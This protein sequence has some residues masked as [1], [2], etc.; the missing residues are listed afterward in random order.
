MTGSVHILR[1]GVALI[2]DAPASDAD[3]ATVVPIGRA[4]AAGSRHRHPAGGARGRVTVDDGS[5]EPWPTAPDDLEDGLPS[6]RSIAH[7]LVESRRWALAAAF[8]R[9]ADLVHGVAR[10]LVGHDHADDVTQQVFVE[11]W[12]SRRSFD[13]S[14]GEVPGWLVGIARNVARSYMRD[15]GPAT[16]DVDEQRDADGAAPGADA[17]VDHLVVASAFRDLPAT[18]R[19]VLELTLL[20]EFTHSEAAAHLGI[21]LGTVKTRHRRGLKAL[22][23]SLAGAVA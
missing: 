7:G 9:W 15:R 3:D 23:A 8:E 11:A 20:G 10:Q 2:E 17:V 18:Q 12:R 19:E 4:S 5:E 14:R 21:P 13:P 16:L 6:E 22:R 1:S